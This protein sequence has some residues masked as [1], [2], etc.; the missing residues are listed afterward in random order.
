MFAVRCAN[1][2]CEAFNVHLQRSATARQFVYRVA[3]NRW[4]IL[5]LKA[6]QERGDST[7]MA[8]AEKY[9]PMQ[10]QD[11]QPW[12]S[13][14]IYNSVEFVLDGLLGRT[15][16]AMRLPQLTEQLSAKF[17]ELLNHNHPAIDTLTINGAA[18][19]APHIGRSIQTLEFEASSEADENT[20][21]AIPAAPVPGAETVG[22]IVKQWKLVQARLA[23]TQN[24]TASHIGTAAAR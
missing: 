18:I 8:S 7:L 6:A 21:P 3:E 2:E 1:C 4:L 20:P 9:V 12:L 17:A 23:A 10:L 16:G 15:E 14:S 24:S 19:P 22:E 11:S 5:E 13:Q